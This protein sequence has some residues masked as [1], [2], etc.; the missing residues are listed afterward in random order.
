MSA[1]ASYKDFIPVFETLNEAIVIFDN[2]TILWTRAIMGFSIAARAVIVLWETH[3]PHI[4]QARE[5][6]KYPGLYSGFEYL[7]NEAKKRYPEINLHEI[8]EWKMR[9]R[10]EIN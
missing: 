5:G 9:I 1:E 6:F 4:N 3:L 2:E 7:Y 8:D 10:N